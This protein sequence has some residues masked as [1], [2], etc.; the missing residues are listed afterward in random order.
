MAL[1][2]SQLL[3]DVTGTVVVGVEL[4]SLNAGKHNGMSFHDSYREVLHHGPGATGPLLALIDTIIPIRW[5]PV[6]KN[7]R[8]T[9]A[10]DAIQGETMRIIK[11]RVE[12]L[13]NES[14]DA[15]FDEGVPLDMLT[16]MVEDKY[17][18][19]D[20]NERWDER[21]IQKQVRGGPYGEVFGSKL[22]LRCR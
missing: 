16:A 10:N 8:Y 11:D 4:D 20:E 12:S 9:L 13:R 1:M 6:A 7:R 15:K 22:S 18:S 3:M 2:L 17:F 5:L 19:D 21:Q 14:L